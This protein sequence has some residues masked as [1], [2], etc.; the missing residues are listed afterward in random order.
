LHLLVID[1]LAVG[2]AMRRGSQGDANANG[3]EALT[4]IT[5][6]G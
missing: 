5:S 6:H 3:E 4:A 2:L 1:I